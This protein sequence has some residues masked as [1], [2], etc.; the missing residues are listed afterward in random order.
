MTLTSNTSCFHM[1]G[2]AVMFPL[3]RCRSSAVFLP[4]MT[5]C[6]AIP[7]CLLVIHPP[8]YLFPH[9]RMLPEPFFHPKVDRV[10]FPVFLSIQEPLDAYSAML[11]DVYRHIWCDFEIAV[12]DVTNRL[13]AQTHGD[14]E[15]DFS[16]V[17]VLA[18][19]GDTLC[20]STV[21]K[22]LL[23]FFTAAVSKP[24]FPHRILDQ[25]SFPFSMNQASSARVTVSVICDMS[26]SA[27]YL[28]QILTG[29]FRSTLPSGPALS[30]PPFC[31][32][33]FAR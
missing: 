29:I 33:C 28:L 30:S 6:L 16:H 5:S 26:M 8:P 25:Q 22:A 20:W 13:V 17:H 18:Q 7:T 32:L 27:K 3:T 10:L 31:M 12:F 23:K 9:L 14:C 4:S 19:L 21:I 15:F 11:S 2:T 24:F 1:S